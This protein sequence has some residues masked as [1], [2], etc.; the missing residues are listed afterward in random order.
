MY[1]ESDYI[2]GRASC[3]IYTSCIYFVVLFL[4]PSERFCMAD[5]ESTSTIVLENAAKYVRECHCVR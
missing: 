4:C 1:S 2:S 5:A 3:M